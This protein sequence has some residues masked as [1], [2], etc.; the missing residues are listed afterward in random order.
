M[1]SISKNL[2]KTKNDDREMIFLDDR[3]TIFFN[4]LNAELLF[5]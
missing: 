4:L 5:L 1:Y 3:E 2:R